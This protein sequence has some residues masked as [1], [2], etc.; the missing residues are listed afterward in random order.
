MIR[1]IRGHHTAKRRKKYALLAKGYRGANS[2]LTT[3]IEE[4]VIQSLNYA[5]IGRHLKKRNF[6]TMWIL[7][8]NAILKIYK[9]TYSK[10][11]GILNSLNIFI[12]R[13]I[14]CFFIFNE[15]ILFRLMYR[16]YLH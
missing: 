6:R 7:R 16:K 9:T 13:K 11:F 10:Y 12:N 2:C 8:I 14:L 5:Y 1:V 3:K 4:Q 15:L